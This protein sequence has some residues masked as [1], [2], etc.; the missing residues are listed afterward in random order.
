[1]PSND[2]SKRP[3]TSDSRPA[4]STPS[5]ATRNAGSSVKEQPGVSTIGPRATGSVVTRRQSRARERALA[6]K[7]RNNTIGAVLAAIVVIAAFVL[8]LKS[9]HGSK[10]KSANAG[11]CPT[12]TSVNGPTAVQTPSATPPAVPAS[13]KTVTGDQGLQYIDFTPGCGTAVQ[14]GDTVNVIYSG[15]LQSNGK[16]FDSSLNHQSQMPGGVFN[17]QNIGQ[18][19]LIPGWNTGIIGMKPGMTRRLIIPPALGYGA[20]GSPPTIPANATLIFDITLVSI[21]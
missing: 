13:A 2:Q 10:P 11:A 5:A 3:A 4:K 8:L 20:A 9:L 17:V 14:Q 6:R 7:R 1:M 19:Q 15:W 12:A 18:A 21:G 16:L